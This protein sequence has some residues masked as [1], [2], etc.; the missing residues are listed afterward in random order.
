MTQ[1]VCTC[2]ITF[3]QLLTYYT[4][5]YLH[6]K[7]IKFQITT[8]LIANL[9]CMEIRDKVDFRNINKLKSDT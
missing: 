2:A 7:R 9:K 1:H 5:T 3:F 4:H 6:E 8:N